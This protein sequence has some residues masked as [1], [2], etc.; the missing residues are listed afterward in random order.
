MDTFGT[1]AGYPEQSI[2][3]PHSPLFQGAFQEDD[4]LLISDTSG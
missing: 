1:T 2:S 3:P 4:I